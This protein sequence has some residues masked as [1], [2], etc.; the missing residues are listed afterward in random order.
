MCVCVCTR[1][2][3]YMYILSSFTHSVASL[4]IWSPLRVRSSSSSRSPSTASG[5]V[6]ALP[7]A[8]ARSRRKVPAALPRRFLLWAAAAMARGVSVAAVA[9]GRRARI[10]SRRCGELPCRCSIEAAPPVRPVRARPTS[11]A[12]WRSERSCAA[13]AAATILLSLPSGCPSRFLLSHSPPPTLSRAA[14]EAAVAVAAPVAAVAA[15][16]GWCCAAARACGAGLRGAC[17]AAGARFARERWPAIAKRTEYL[18][19]FCL[20]CCSLCSWFLCCCFTASASPCT[21]THCC[22]QCLCSCLWSGPSYCSVLLAY[23]LDRSFSSFFFECRFSSR[24]AGPLPFVHCSCACAETVNM[25]FSESAS[26]RFP[27]ASMA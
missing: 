16:D 18:A 1:A 15:A 21:A 24:F 12:N 2:H 13:S 23:C 7:W 6:P 25:N 14:S 26:E 11:E 4:S 27:A 17:G 10:L 9:V 3:P 8:F 5:L 19:A 20:R 22:T